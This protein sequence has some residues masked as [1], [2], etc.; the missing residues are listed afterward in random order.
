M[1]KRRTLIVPDVEEICRPCSI[2][3]LRRVPCFWSNFNPACSF[4]IIDS[5]GCDVI[6]G[7]F[8]KGRFNS[9][10][11]T[12]LIIALPARKWSVA[13]LRKSNVS[14]YNRKQ[15]ESWKDLTWHGQSMII[16]TTL[17]IIISCGISAN[18]IY[19]LHLLTWNKKH[20][21]N[22]NQ[23]Q[24]IFGVAWKKLQSKRTSKDN[25]S[26]T[27][28]LLPYCVIQCIKIEHKIWK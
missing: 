18:L 4:K 23:Y 16:I 22:S 13:R 28:Q 17:R 3:S 11:E 20:S 5:S 6:S 21:S 14:E 9:G 10:M 25:S 26:S 8:K 12:K 15:I 7:D 27:T 24:P 2:S 1:Q 19:A